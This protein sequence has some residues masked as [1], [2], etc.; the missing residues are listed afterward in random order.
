MPQITGLHGADHCCHLG[1][2]LRHSKN[3]FSVL[4]GLQFQPLQ[5]PHSGDIKASLLVLVKGAATPFSS[6]IQVPILSI[7][8]PHSERHSDPHFSAIQALIPAS[9]R[10]SFQRH[11]SADLC[12]CKPPVTSTIQALFKHR[13]ICCFFR[14]C[15]RNSEPHSERH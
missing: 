6:A 11:S 14:H 9:F 15:I 10:R 1:V 4:L 5:A 3:A 12:R 7:I 8:Q 13:C 2:I